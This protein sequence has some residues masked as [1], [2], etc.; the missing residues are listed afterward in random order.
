MRN[1]DPQG[2]FFKEQNKAHARD[3]LWMPNS[4]KPKCAT[5]PLYHFM[6]QNVYCNSDIIVMV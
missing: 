5:T 6:V 1:I 2:K 4:F 3:S